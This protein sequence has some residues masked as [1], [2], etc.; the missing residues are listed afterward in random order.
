MPSDYFTEYLLCLAYILSQLI[1][2]PMHLGLF[3]G[4]HSFA[5]WLLTGAQLCGGERKPTYSEGG[6]EG[7]KRLHIE[8]IQG[9]SIAAKL[10]ESYHIFLK[11]TRLIKMWQFVMHFGAKSFL[12]NIRVDT[13][14]CNFNFSITKV[15]DA[16]SYLLALSVCASCLLSLS[17]PLLTLPLALTA[18]HQHSLSSSFALWLPPY[19]ALFLQ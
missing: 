12:R 9:I 13:N 10:S 14:Q 2:H 7:G 17:L 4:T 11:M 18:P 16:F 15:T 19:F 6:R 8:P 1:F 5:M 3:V